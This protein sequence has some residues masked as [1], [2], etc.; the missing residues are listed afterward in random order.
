MSEAVPSRAFTDVYEE[1]A[2]L[3]QGVRAEIIDGVLEVQPR[4]SWSHGHVAAEMAFDIAGSRR[5]PP[6]T[7]PSWKFLV[8]PELWLGPDVIV[9]DVAGWRFERFPFNVTQGSAVA[10]D[11][12]AEVLS[13]STARR[14]RGPKLHIYRQAGVRHVWL[15]DPAL[16]TVEIFR[17]S[18][19]GYTLVCVITDSERTAMEPFDDVEFEV[20]RWWY[21]APAEPGV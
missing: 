14:D 21:K 20:E 2:S 9:P 17:L 15:V 11:W 8:E 3:E 19:E 10:P 4:P 5:G 18:A 16:E 7:P 13:P 6:G 1:Y 12:I